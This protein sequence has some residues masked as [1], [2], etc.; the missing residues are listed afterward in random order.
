MKALLQLKQYRETFYIKP[1]NR[2]WCL[3]S[4]EEGQVKQI[5]LITPSNRQSD[6]PKTKFRVQNLPRYNCR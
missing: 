1:I 6:M 2:P 4:V 5:L 3:A